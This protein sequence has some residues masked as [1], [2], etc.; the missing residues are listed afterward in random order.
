MIKLALSISAFGV[1]VLACYLLAV[2]S[3]I[4]PFFAIAIAVIVVPIL[5][6]LWRSIAKPGA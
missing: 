1:T 2:I 4:Y 5:Y 6:L 3:W